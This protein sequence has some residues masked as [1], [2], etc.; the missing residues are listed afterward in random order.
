M[1][2]P[3]VRI[4]PIKLL[5]GAILKEATPGPVEKGPRIYRFVNGSGLALRVMPNGRKFFIYC[6]TSD[7]TDAGGK[8]KQARVATGIEWTPNSGNVEEAKEWMR[9]N[10]GKRP[11]T[12]R[13]RAAKARQE[14][15]QS[16]K[17]ITVG[18]LIDR[19]LHEYAS[20]KRSGREDVSRLNNHVRPEWGDR[21]AKDITRADVDQLVSWVA[22]GDEARGIPPRKAE[23]NHRLAVVRK[24]FSFAVDKGIIEHH[25]CLR[26]AAPGGKIANRTRAL[27]TPKELRLLWRITD[28]SGPW[29]KPKREGWPRDV[30]WEARGR[31]SPTIADAL[32]LVLATGCRANEAAQAPW[33][34]FDLDEAVWIIDGSRTKN[35]LTHLVPLTP[36]V[37]SM[38]R[39][40]RAEVGGEYVF[41]SKW[42][43]S[44]KAKKKA[45]K[46]HINDKHLSEALG[47]ACARLR[48]IGLDPFTTHDLRRTVKTGMAAAKVPKEIRD[49]VQ[50]HK[51][52]SVGEGYNF[53]DYAD[54]K[55]EAL[56]KWARRLE[57]M[58]RP[59]ADN[60]VQMRR[61]KA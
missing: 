19:Y 41:P 57:T 38:L 30:P 59:E 46:P 23:A 25:P 51:D 43:Y 42:F 47:F 21:K 55:R 22:V 14:H 28:R 3:R 13:K 8:R 35:G 29:T 56:E 37:V 53:H 27:T 45:Y 6:Y 33:S 11:E 9:N 50:N 2:A 39:Q 17:E 18:K 31:M 54:E 10:A 44:P 1:T 32:R 7:E 61:G 58:L 26:M 60:V 49:R 24:L 12:R 4:D 36:E 15:Q 40:R 52:P 16:V 20:K 34:E 48:R 5:E